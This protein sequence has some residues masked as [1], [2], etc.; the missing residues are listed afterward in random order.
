MVKMVGVREQKKVFWDVVELF[1]L[2]QQR[3]FLI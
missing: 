3:F 2:L 1:E